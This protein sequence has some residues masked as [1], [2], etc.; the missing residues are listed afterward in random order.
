M[1]VTTAGSKLWRFGYP[2]D[3]SRK[4][5]AIGPYPIVSLVDA[6]AKR[7]DAKRLLVEGIDPSVERKAERRDAGIARS[8]TF[9]ASP[10][11]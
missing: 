10:T 4:L 11:S 5:L 6:R 3:A 9:E 7:D 1:L 2:Y 8:N